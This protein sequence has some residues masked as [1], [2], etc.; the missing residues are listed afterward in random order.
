MRERAR[1]NT[2]TT[3]LP[4]WVCSVEQPYAPWVVY[5][6][7]P[8]RLRGCERIKEISDRMTPELFLFVV[9]PVGAV[10]LLVIA[11]WRAVRD[12]PH[13]RELG[14]ANSARRPIHAGPQHAAG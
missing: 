2:A 4:C 12:D 11:H 3:G 6:E 10:A 9:V 14:T 13:E 7:N 5:A 1:P 8:R